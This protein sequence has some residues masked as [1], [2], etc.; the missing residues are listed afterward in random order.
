MTD[1]GQRYRDAAHAMLTGTGYELASDPQ[2]PDKNNHHKHLQS[3]INAAHVS[4][5]AIARL[6]IDKGIIT[7]DEYTAACADAMETEVKRMEAELEH[8]YGTKVELR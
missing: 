4:Q 6:L 3:G 1:D 7:F 8:R 2:R 5:A